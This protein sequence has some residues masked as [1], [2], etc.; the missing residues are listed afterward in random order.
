[1]EERIKLT[2]GELLIR[3]YSSNI[4]AYCGAWIHYSFDGC[5]EFETN[6]NIDDFIFNHLVKIIELTKEDIKKLNYE[7]HNIFYAHSL[8]VNEVR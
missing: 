1:M 2:N 5:D 8:E 3:V 7:L 6:E 4:E